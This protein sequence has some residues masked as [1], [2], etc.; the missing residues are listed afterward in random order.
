MHDIVVTDDASVQDRGNGIRKIHGIVVKYDA[1]MQDRRNGIRR[2][3]KYV[4][5]YFQDHL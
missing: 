1:S 2:Y 3:Q 5:G 4:K